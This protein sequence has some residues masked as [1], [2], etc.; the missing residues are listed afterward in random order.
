LIPPHYDGPPLP[1]GYSTLQSPTNNVFLFVRAFLEPGADGPDPTDGV[2]AL[3]R[4]VIYPLRQTS[5]ARWKPMQ[6]PDAS[7]VAIDM[8]YP[9]DATYFGQARPVHP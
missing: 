9:R 3:E 5:P 8:M 7:G 6:F 1:G 4:T 2:A